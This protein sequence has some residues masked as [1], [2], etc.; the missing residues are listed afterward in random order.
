MS[1]S[2]S[3]GSGPR[4][5]TRPSFAL[6]LRGPGGAPVR[7]ALLELLE[8]LRPVGLEELRERAV[9][10]E[11]PAGLAPRA[12]VRLVVAA[13]DPLDRRAARGAGLLVPQMDREALAGGRDAL[14]RE[15]LARL[16]A[17]AR[18]PFLEDILRGLEERLRLLGREPRRQ[19]HGREPCAV[20]DLVRVGVPDPA[21]ESR[22]HESDLDRMVLPGE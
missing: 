17:Q 8:R 21:E 18:R 4:G 5:R 20:E 6:Y 16:A 2:T 3:R 7:H 15:A 14:V 19:L 9:G 10:E 13:D 22:I 11:L 12:V 1:W